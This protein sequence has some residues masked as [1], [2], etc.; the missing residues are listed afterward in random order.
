MTNDDVTIFD[1]EITA[2]TVLKDARLDEIMGFGPDYKAMV[3]KRPGWYAS[4][5]HAYRLWGPPTARR[6]RT[7][8]RKTITRKV[9]RAHRQGRHIHAC[10]VAQEETKRPR[11]DAAAARR[12]GQAQARYQ[13]KRRRRELQAGRGWTETHH[14]KRPRQVAA[15]FLKEIER[16]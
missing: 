3:A 2:A 15:L 5:G 1:L 7:L 14:V 8:S 4:T 16:R 12:A 10:D 9:R 11:A 13:R 6:L